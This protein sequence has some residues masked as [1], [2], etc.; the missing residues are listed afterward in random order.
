M[1]RAPAIAP[2]GLSATLDR[3]PL[4]AALVAL[5]KVIDGKAVNPVYSHLLVRSEVDTLVMTAANGE[6]QA[7]VRIVAVVETPGAITIPAKELHDFAGTAPAGGKI[8]IDV[9]PDRRVSILRCGRARY[10]LPG[11]EPNTFHLFDEAVAF[12]HS[13]DLMGSILSGALARSMFAIATEE[14]RV[15]LTGAFLHVVEVAGTPTLR[16]VTTDGKRLARIDLSEEASLDPGMQGVILPRRTCELLKILGD[17]L[18][19]ERIRLD[20]AK[21]LVLITGGDLVIASRLLDGTFP[22]YD[23][24]IPIGNS[25]HVVAPAAAL[26]AAVK[27]VAKLALDKVRTVSLSLDGDR[28]GFECQNNDGGSAS[29]EIEV[30]YAGDSLEIRFNAQWLAEMIAAT[31]GETVLIELE[32]PNDICVFRHREGGAALYVLSPILR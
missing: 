27:R 30:E 21:S 12:T 26:S 14:T 3:G 23:R 17:T 29:D 11:Y 15:F 1:A 28:L 25:R 6:I 20:V 10:T 24:V 13:I 5:L 32:G 16:L 22:D 8:T 2:G 9:D 7:T 18:G 19:E 4:V 31:G